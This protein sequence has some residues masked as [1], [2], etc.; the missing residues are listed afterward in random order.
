MHSRR[1]TI[2]NCYN[3]WA[4]SWVRYWKFTPILIAHV[5]NRETHTVVSSE[6]E[7]IK[8]YMQGELDE[9]GRN[10]TYLVAKDQSGK[11]VGCM[12]YSSPDPDMVVH[13]QLE[14]TDEAIELLNAFVSPEIFRGGGVGRKLLESICDRSS[15]KLKQLLIHSG[16]RYQDSWVLW[17]K[18]VEIMDSFKTSMEQVDM[19]KPG[20]LSCNLLSNSSKCT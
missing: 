6:I 13:F 12:A 8:G 4:T 17:Q 15:A 10:R 1:K 16:P 3:C 9:Y 2:T 7:A 5:W 18:W 11:V 14:N 20:R 19:Q